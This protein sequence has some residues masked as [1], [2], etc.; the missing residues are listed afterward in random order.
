[1]NGGTDPALYVVSGTLTATPARP[2][3]Q[4]IG[5]PPHRPVPGAIVTLTAT[6]TTVATTTT[7]DTGRFSFTLP[8][9]NYDIT[10]TGT[11]YRV[12]PTQP[13]TVT[14]PTTVTLVVDSGMR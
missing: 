4:R 1:M 9:G 3:P 12:Q 8:P 13:I 11:G 7:D 5:D 10:A 14:G 6:G 2:G